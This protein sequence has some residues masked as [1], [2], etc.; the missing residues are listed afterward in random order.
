MITPGQCRAARAWLGW[1]QQD[2]ADISMVGLSAL[3]D[4]ETQKR[5]T[6]AP[7][8]LALKRALEAAGLTFPAEG[9]VRAAPGVEEG[10][11]ENKRFLD[12]VGGSS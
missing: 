4:F 9:I 1:T 6:T 7:N 8:V 10:Y 12:P 11:N 5:Q 2:L 3:K